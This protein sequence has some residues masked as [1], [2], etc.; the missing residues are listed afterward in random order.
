MK[1]KGRKAA[2]RSAAEAG[3]V[4]SKSA[5]LCRYAGKARSSTERFIQVRGALP[6]NR[7]SMWLA[8]RRGERLMACTVVPAMWLVTVQLSRQIMR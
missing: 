4:P 5:V 1:I 8:R 7:L 2:R 3:G 6:S